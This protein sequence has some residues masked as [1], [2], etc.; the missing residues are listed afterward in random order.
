MSSAF[1]DALAKLKSPVKELVTVV[2]DN[3]QKH[4]GETETDRQQV[5]T[6]IE[7]SN[8]IVGDADLQ[9]RRSPS[10]SLRA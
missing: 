3:G 4:I 2:T 7:N 9:V 10:L 8:D 1:H 5:V 6:W